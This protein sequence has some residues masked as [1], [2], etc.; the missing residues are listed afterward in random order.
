MV[1]EC[2]QAG[3]GFVPSRLTSFRL[4]ADRLKASA[5]LRSCHTLLWPLKSCVGALVEEWQDGRIYVCPVLVLKPLLRYCNGR[6][7]S[8]SFRQVLITET[9]NKIMH[10]QFIL[11]VQFVQFYVSVE[12]IGI[13]PTDFMVVSI[14]FKSLISLVL[15]SYHKLWAGMAMR[16]ETGEIKIR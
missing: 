16:V 6:A 13:K 1:L 8:C 3:Q 10:R 11:W 4:A 7:Y 9:S 15:T 12:I 2:F 14:C 5:T